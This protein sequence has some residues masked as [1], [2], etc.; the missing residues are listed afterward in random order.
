[1]AQVGA[2]CHSARMKKQY[3]TSPRRSPFSVLRQ[4]C[5]L[6]PAHLAPKP[7]RETS[8]DRKARTFKAAEPSGQ[9]HPC[10]THARHRPRRLGYWMN[11]TAEFAGRLLGRSR[12][13]RGGRGA[14]AWGW[15]GT[16]TEARPSPG[17]FRHGGLETCSF[18][19]RRVDGACNVM[20]FRRSG[21]HPISAL[22]SKKLPLVYYV[23]PHSLHS[24]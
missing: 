1:M 19:S 21:F 23:R 10:A 22:N 5:H 16:R 6:I 20:R 13:G 14:S 3:P 11:R 2:F 15:S 18:S 17:V 4:I 7:A 12:G 24:S 8:V 9:P